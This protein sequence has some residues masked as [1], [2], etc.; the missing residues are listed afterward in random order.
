MYAVEFDMS[1][2]SDTAR[3]QQLIGSLAKSGAPMAKFGWGKSN[4]DTL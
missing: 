4:V 2:T 1:K 3:K